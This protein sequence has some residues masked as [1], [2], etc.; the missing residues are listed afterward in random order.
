MSLLR[1]A[2]GM[3][4]INEGKRLLRGNDTFTTFPSMN[5]MLRDMAAING[6]FITQ[7]HHIML[8]TLEEA[9]EVLDDLL[10]GVDDFFS[11]R[12]GPGNIKDGLDGF[13]NLSK[14]MTYH[15]ANG[16]LVINFKS[17]KIQAIEYKLLG[18]S[19]I[20]ITGY[21]GL[22]RILN[23]TR[24]GARNPQ[25]L[26]MALG[27]R[28]LGGAFI[29]G[30]RFCIYCALAF[31][32]V[33]LIFKSD[34]HLT[35]FLV[36]VSV[37]IAKIVV[38]SVVIAIVGMG[39]AIVGSPIVLTIGLIIAIGIGLNIGLNKL[40]EKNGLSDSLKEKL[41][42]TLIEEQRMKEWNSAHTSTFFNLL[43]NTSD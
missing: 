4:R 9:Q 18:Q 34:Y 25:V 26:E 35:D 41:R 8:L 7:N 10:G 32:A 37:D 40:D 43:A 19:Y 21:A 3:A 33:E 16:K 28:G 20:R 6:T 1:G 5:P 29:K 12:A 23:G 14:L 15:D 17:L 22:R 30:T 13:R 42:N 39:L 24:Y 27:W 2:D 38:S 11:F 31:R 36:D